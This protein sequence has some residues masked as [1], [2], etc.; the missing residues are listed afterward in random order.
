[1]PLFVESG[2]FSGVVACGRRSDRI[3]LGRVEIAYPNQRER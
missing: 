1:V 3:V 2:E